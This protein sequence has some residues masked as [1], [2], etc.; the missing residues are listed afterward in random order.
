MKTL[1]MDA[2]RMRRHN[3]EQVLRIVRNLGPLSRTEIGRHSKLSAPTVAAAIT[4]LV[5]S[6]MVEESGEGKSTG[7]RRPQLVSFNS[8]FGA[9]IAG[10]IGAT[11]VRLVLADMSGQSIAKRTVGIEDDTR[12]GPVLDRIAEAVAEMRATDLDGVPLLATVVGAPG[13]TDM[14]R[15]V[16]LEA[17]NLDG[18]N[19]VPARDILERAIGVPVTVDNDVNLAAVGEASGG[20]LAGARRRRRSRGSRPR[21]SRRPTPGSR[22]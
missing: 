2:R 4:G 21:R 8:R 19:D 5:R 7:G 16:V 15:G 12:P 6:R 22:R 10:N 20:R 3:A 1:P 17:A 18:W 9:V 11:A 14:K 13:M